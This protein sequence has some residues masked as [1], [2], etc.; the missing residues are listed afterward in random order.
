MQVL[1]V[2][3]PMFPGEPAMSII[4]EPRDTSRNLAAPCVS[5]ETP[6]GGEVRVQPLPRMAGG[7]PARDRIRLRRTYGPQ[8]RQT[9]Q[10]MSLA[11]E[12]AGTPAPSSRHERLRALA[13]LAA[14]HLYLTQEWAWLD[15]AMLEAAVGPHLPLARCVASGLRRLPTYRGAAIVRTDAVG[16]VTDW[17]REN[18]FVVDQ[19]FWTASTSATALRDCGPGFLVWSLTGRLTQMVDPHAPAR[20]VFTPGTRFKGLQV[21]E[22]RRPVVFLREL[23]LEATGDHPPT[24]NHSD[25]TDESILAELRRAAEQAVTRRDVVDV[26]GPRERLPG[27]IITHRSAGRTGR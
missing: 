14:L 9:M 16:M 7:S 21:S 26:T 11:L 18:R 1:A 23:P 27:L 12:K 20:L 8:Y 10:A 22:S 6:D 2:R 25:R 15:S 3:A 19:G 24:S 4:E 5:W 13:D 17:Y